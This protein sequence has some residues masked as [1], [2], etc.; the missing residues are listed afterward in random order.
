MSIKDELELNTV[1]ESLGDTAEKED[2][3]TEEDT[4]IIS[5][6][7]AEAIEAYEEEPTAEE[8]KKKKKPFIQ[9]PVIISLCI[10]V[11]ALIGYFTFT[12]FF[13][14]EPEGVTW[15]TTYD[16]V[17]YYF[18]FKDGGVVKAHVGSIEITGDYEKF[19]NDGESSIIVNAE[20]GEF[21]S[22]STATYS[23]TGS[24][25]LNN[26]EF[27]IKYSDDNQFTLT[28]TSGWQY[29]LEL[30]SEFVPDEKLFGEW[31]FTYY[32]YEYCRVT[33]NSDGS[34]KID[35]SQ[36]GVAY[37]GVYTVE[38][39]KVNFTFYIG[40][41]VVQPIEYTVDGDVLNFMGMNF[42]RVGSKATVDEY[43]IPQN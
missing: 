39:G 32:G 2:I 16:E 36:N 14:R 29:P 15:M 3:V 24:R 30:P 20:V 5:E 11:L 4:E 18:E 43:A 42:V 19:N 12:S 23:I 41:S 21:Y 31:V 26:Q 1:D 13:L 34:M 7:K 27:N 17:P 35:Y 40:E 10:V 37:N 22:G 9:V 25:I 28:Q 33:F 6:K 38:D 8:P